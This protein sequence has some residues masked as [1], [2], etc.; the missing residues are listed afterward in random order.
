MTFVLPGAA[1]EERWEANLRLLP[2]HSPIYH[3]DLVAA[4]DVV[5]GKLGYSTVAEAV[6]AGSR[7]LFVRRPG[8]RES[9]ILETYVDENLPAEAI[10]SGELEGG[11]WV[12]RLPELIQRTRPPGAAGGGAAVAA[13]LIR[14]W[15]EDRYRVCGFPG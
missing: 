5:V 3:P 7:V 10:S 13:T 14:T 4:A 8:F 15:W 12:D 6:T 2:H 9:A 1:A 11:S